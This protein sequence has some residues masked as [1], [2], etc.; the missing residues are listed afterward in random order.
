MRAYLW[1][2]L[3]DHSSGTPVL[4][5]L[6]PILSLRFVLRQ[7]SSSDDIVPQYNCLRECR[8]WRIEWVGL[9]QTIGN[10]AYL[11][12]QAPISLPLSQK[13]AIPGFAFLSDSLSRYR[14]FAPC[15]TPLHQSL[16]SE[17]SA[18]KSPRSLIR[19]NTKRGKSYISRFL[20]TEACEGWLNG[21]MR[22]ECTTTTCYSCEN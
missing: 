11:L 5:S 20:Q 8:G 10:R 22:Y 2:L 14:I 18:H 13:P 3:E 9:F 16:A 19:L 15:V 12:F 1:T 6:L 4:R 7:L 17:L 21:I